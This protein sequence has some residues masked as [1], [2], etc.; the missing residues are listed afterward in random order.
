MLPDF[1]ALCVRRVLCHNILFNQ[2]RGLFQR[3]I[4]K[5]SKM[6]LCLDHLSNVSAK[7]DM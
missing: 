7:T 1:G 3:G 5:V 4:R 2:E 6:G